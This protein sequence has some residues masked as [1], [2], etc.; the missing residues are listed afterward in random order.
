MNKYDLVI[1]DR[2]FSSWSLRGWL[3]LVKFNLPYRVTL[4][5]LY[6]GTLA[7]DL[8]PYAPARLVPVLRTP[9]GDVVGETLA[10]AET[11]AERHPEAG[12]YPA[13]P[14]ARVLCRWL[15]AE[16]HA[17]FGALRDACPMY[18]IHG[19]EGFT[20]SDAV[21]ADLARVEELWALA[22]S[23][24]GDSGPWLFGDYTLADA[25]YA[26]V[27]MRIAAYGLPVGAE[28]QAYVQAHLEDADLR[29]WR[30]MGFARHY[31]ALPY[32]MDL[33]KTPWPGPT[34]PPG[35]AVDEGPSVNAACP[36][37]GDPVTHFMELDGKVFGFCNAFCRDKAAADPGAWP[38]FVEL[39]RSVIDHV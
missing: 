36:F 28:A 24:H 4:A 35:K 26:P 1:G 7:E 6:A 3:M 10:M 5:G 23:R 14:S 38:A 21:R 13:D 12:L 19:W 30:A 2:L 37:S 8:A 9:E 17:G 32:Q 15:V 39:H 25:F 29:R 31:D 16:M 20:P 27:A 11:L 33:P 34:S 22:R 18:L